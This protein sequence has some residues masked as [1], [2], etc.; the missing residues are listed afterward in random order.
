M[1]N[2]MIGTIVLLGLTLGIAT[3]V[4]AQAGVT[5]TSGFQVQNLESETATIQLNFYNQDGSLAASPTYTVAGNSSRTFYPI[6]DVSSGFNGSLVISSDRDI[7]AINN[8]LG[9]GVGSYFASTNGFQNG[10]TE[11]NL[12]LIMC[13]NSGFDTWFN[14]QNTSSSENATVYINYV[15][16]SNGMPGSETA[17]IAPGAAKTFSQ[18]IGSSTVNCS[19]LADGSG[20]FIGSAVITA[21]QPVAAVVM[22]I[23]TGGFKVLMGYGGFTSG[24]PTVALPLIMANNNGFY[25]GIQVQNVGDTP[26]TVT[27]DYTPN[28]VAGGSDPS[29]ETFDLAPGASKTIIQNGAPP[30]NGSVNNWNVIGR[31][32][33]GAMITNSGN[34]PLVAIVNQVRPGSN[35]LGTAYEG[36]DPAAATTRVSAPLIMANN[37]TYYTGIQVQNVSNDTVHVVIDYGPNTAGTFNP[38][39][40]EFDLDPGTSKTIIQNG[41]PPANGSTVNN[42]GTNRYIGS[43]TITAT[44][45]IVAIVNQ[46]SLSRPG[47]QFATTDA[48][49]Y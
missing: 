1:R 19:T 34:Q 7:R 25:T 30:A 4:S 29:D 47:D 23:N 39:N 16:G 32:I 22:Q 5:Y 27:V 26:T 36:F 11:V 9:S 35:A 42:W 2:L 37:S 28:T 33:G 20:K 49:N 13:N 48:F 14:V 6:N 24:S 45:N 18:A 40:E 21:T 43:A 10:S 12:P 46:V 38:A 3:L 31:Y 8:L 15:P 41:A 17:V 44:G